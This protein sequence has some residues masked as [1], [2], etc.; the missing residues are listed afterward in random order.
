MD[1]AGTASLTGRF[2]RRNQL[3]AS[4]AFPS[5]G[6]RR[7]RFSTLIAKAR[8][9]GQGDPAVHTKHA[10][11]L[12]AGEYCSVSMLLTYRVF[13]LLRPVC[14]IVFL[15]E[16]AN[17]GPLLVVES[18]KPQNHCIAGRRLQGPVNAFPAGKIYILDICPR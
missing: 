13:R 7:T 17:P 3:S 6:F 4:R 15:Y 9:L 18:V 16:L 1:K 10:A 11:A 14:L 12:S 2:V 5:R 8:I